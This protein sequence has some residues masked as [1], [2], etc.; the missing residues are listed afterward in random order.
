MPRYS[1]SRRMC[2]PRS[3]VN[4]QCAMEGLTVGPNAIHRNEL[5][6][7]LQSP[8][9]DLKELPGFFIFQVVHNPN[10]QHHIKTLF[11]GQ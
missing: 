10:R 2:S 6:T 7:W 1:R 11:V 4:N 8:V 9:R 3:L 5:A